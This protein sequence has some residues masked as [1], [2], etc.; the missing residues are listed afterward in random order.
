MFLPWILPVFLA[1]FL[2]AAAGGA[3]GAAQD[4]QAQAP[5]SPRDAVARELLERHSERSIGLGVTNG[6]GVFELFAAAGG[7]TWTLILILPDGRVMVIEAGEDWSRPPF[8]PMEP[9][10]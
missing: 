2:L 7:E 8:R 4:G 1:G 6:G 10:A 3:P 9:S 5:I